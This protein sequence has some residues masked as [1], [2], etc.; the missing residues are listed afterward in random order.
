MTS[1]LA[2]TLWLVWRL[3]LWLGPLT[4]LALLAWLM[5]Q[6]RPPQVFA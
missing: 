4:G 1:G 6:P 3:L 2:L 5:F